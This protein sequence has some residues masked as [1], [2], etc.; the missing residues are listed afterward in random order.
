MAGVCLITGA[1]GLVGRHVLQQWTIDGLQPIGVD[2]NEVDLLVPGAA[3]DLVGRVRPAVVLHLAW[4]ASGTDGY[5]THPDNDAWVRATLELATACHENGAW[6]VATG[7]AIDA[8]PAPGD[9]YSRSKS[10]LRAELQPAVD[11]GECTWLRPYYIVDPVLRRPALVA[12]TLDARDKARSVALATPDASHDFVH[13][14]DVGTAIVRVV[15][16]GLRGEVPIGS[17]Y[18]RRVADL[19]TALG[20]T[21]I[22]AARST[23]VAAHHGAV[24]DIQQLRDHGWSPTFTKQLFDGG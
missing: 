4:S 2:R 17:G 12:E 19:V 9:A 21:W 8:E 10:R 14:A 3:A 11:A 6:L 1:T 18:L 16:N 13:A 23:E 15:D 7:S 22:P 20:A 5:R 24:A